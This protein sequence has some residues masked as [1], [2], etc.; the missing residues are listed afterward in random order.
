MVTHVLSGISATTYSNDRQSNDGIFKKTVV[1]MM[2]YDSTVEDVRIELVTGVSVAGSQSLV[3]AAAKTELVYSITTPSRIFNDTSMATARFIQSLNESITTGMF[4][5][6]LRDAGTNELQA[7]ATEYVIF[8]TASPTSLPTSTSQPSS[9]PTSQSVLTDV[10]NANTLSEP[11]TGKV[12]SEKVNYYLGT[13]HL[14]CT[15]YCT[16]AIT[17]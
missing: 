10:I 14:V 2:G 17:N 8:S 7:V 4:D 16:P 6:V 3:S 1:T 12:V 5:A 9:T 13:T 15:N 11:I